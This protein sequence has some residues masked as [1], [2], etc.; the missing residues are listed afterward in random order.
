MNENRELQISDCRFQMM[1]LATNVAWFQNRQISD[2]RSK[3]IVDFRSIS[4][5]KLKIADNYRFQISSDCKL[6]ISNHYCPASLNLKSSEIICNLESEIC[7]L[8]SAVC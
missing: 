7:N 6:Q 8:E 4:D 1:W 2:C 3:I 5:C